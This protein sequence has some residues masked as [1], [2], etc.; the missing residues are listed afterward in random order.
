M[1]KAYKLLSIFMVS[2]MLVCTLSTT[3]YAANKTNTTSDT[4]KPGDIVATSTGADENIKNIGGKIL[5]AVT[6]IG[7]ALSVVMLTVL[8]VKY[9]M[10]SAEE[11][12]EY[13]KSMMPYLIGAILIFGASTIATAVYNLVQF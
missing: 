13:K 8:G 6:T 9:M 2:I 4:I 7:I 1:K 11:K 3:L 12:A 5:S 10:G